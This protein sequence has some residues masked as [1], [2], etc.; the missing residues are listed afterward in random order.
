MLQSKVGVVI[1]L[2]NYKYSVNPRTEEP[3]KMKISSNM[4]TPD[5]EI[6]LDVEEI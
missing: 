5:G 6:W 2:Q 4:L 3:L 1:L